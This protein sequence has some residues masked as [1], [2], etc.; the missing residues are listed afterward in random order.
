[1]ALTIIPFGKRRR[2]AAPAA[3]TPCAPAGGASEGAFADAILDDVVRHRAR[4]IRA[5]WWQV[6]RLL[7]ASA[8]L[9]FVAM[10]AFPHPVRFH[11]RSKQSEAKT[12]LKATYV[13]MEA[14]RGEFDGYPR[15]L[16]RA[17]ELNDPDGRLGGRY[18]V[19]LASVSDDAFVVLAL[20]RPGTSVAGE[21][22][23][24]DERNQLS[25]EQ[26]VCF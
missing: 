3:P 6:R 9:S 25:V 16:P 24:I 26:N 14:H 1:M 10:F 7:I 15:E 4:R 8:V 13:A 19:H 23:R 18:W 17:E 20:G 22:W 21:L 12:K 2:R 5:I 11:C